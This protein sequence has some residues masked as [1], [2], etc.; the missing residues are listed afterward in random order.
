MWFKP[1]FKVTN[2]PPKEVAFFYAQYIEV[3]KFGSDFHDARLKEYL[4][5]ILIELGLPHRDLYL[6]VPEN[7]ETVEAAPSP[8]KRKL[9]VHRKDRIDEITY[10]QYGNKK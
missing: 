10:E 7:P 1:K 9:F 4:F 2:A 6:E 5:D 8:E 3:M